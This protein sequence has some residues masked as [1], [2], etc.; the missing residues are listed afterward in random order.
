[1]R[2]DDLGVASDGRA[3][4]VVG[5]T[6]G[7]HWLFDATTREWTAL[8]PP[9]VAPVGGDDRRTGF[10]SVTAEC[11]A[12]DTLVVMEPAVSG[13]PRSG[14]SGGGGGGVRTHVLDVVAGGDWTTLADA[15]QVA[16][17][18]DPLVSCAGSHAI[19]TDGAT[20]G[21]LV[22][23]AG[24][25]RSGGWQ[26][27]LADG[28]WS[29]LP[30]S[31]DLPMSDGL[32]AGPFVTRLWTGA[33]LLLLPLGGEQPGLAYDPVAGA[34]RALADVPG[35]AMAA[36]WADDRVFAVPEGSSSTVPDGTLFS[37]VPATR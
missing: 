20:A 4:L 32:P 5:E 27:D 26:L 24:N 18:M 29:D 1:M 31:P 28:T 35:D 13:D 6:R 36:I 14:G 37:Y 19:V 30:R 17:E 33:E 21:V 23:L 2:V 3:V 7:E 12:G 22:D 16:G 34:W 15:P 9:P 10:S 25:E 11:L 8:P